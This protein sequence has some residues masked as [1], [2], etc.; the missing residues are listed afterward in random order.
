MPVVSSENHYHISGVMVNMCTL[1]VVDRGLEY[2]LGEA[3]CL[4]MDCYFSELT[5]L[6]S[7]WECWSSTK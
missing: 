6:N 2:W 4:L 3:I 5:L 7:N 1:S